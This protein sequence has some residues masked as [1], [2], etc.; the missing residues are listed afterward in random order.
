MI[1]LRS[2]LLILLH[3]FGFTLFFW[4]LL[5]LLLLLL[6]L[7][8]LFFPL[9]ALH[10]SDAI[11]IKCKH[12][13]I[14]IYFTALLSAFTKIRS[15][16]NSNDDDLNMEIV[17]RFLFRIPF[18]YREINCFHRV[19]FALNFFRPLLSW[20]FDLWRFTAV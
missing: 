4:W 7:R 18:I 19:L 17:E 15:V 1:S 5:S 10:K 11:T 9:N 13:K 2:W 12:Y 14:Y 16:R 6:L 20:K 3:S 8:Y